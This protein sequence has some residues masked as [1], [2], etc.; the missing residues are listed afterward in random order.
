MARLPFRRLPIGRRSRIL[1]AMAEPVATAPS[2]RPPLAVL[3]D[4]HANLEA[5][6]AVLADLEAVLGRAPEGGDMVHLG[7]LVGYGPDP[8]ACAGLLLGLGAPCLLGNHEKGLR[9]RENP[10]AM[11]PVARDAL[12]RT[13][14]LLAEETA[15]RLRSLP[16]ALEVRGCLCVHGCP[17]D[18]PTRYLHNVPSEERAAL[19]ASFGQRVCLCGHTHDLRLW[20]LHEDGGGQVAVRSLHRGETRLDPAAR[21]IVNAGSVGQPRDGDPSA[22]YLLLD[23]ETLALE[24]RFVPYDA[25]A[26][27]AKLERLG[28]SKSLAVRLRG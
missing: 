18:S 22:K 20:T 16:R 15:A 12:N 1:L 6:T 13:A 19:F 5:L 11:N 9:P 3:S 25:E 26:T 8:E 23:T 7:D 21:H 28:F 17:P 27:I 10:T 14:V 4:V 24:V 2:R